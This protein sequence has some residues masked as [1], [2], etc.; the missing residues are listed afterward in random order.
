MATTRLVGLL[1]ASDSIS[2]SVNLLRREEK[3]KQQ[4]TDSRVFSCKVDGERAHDLNGIGID[5]QLGLP[6]LAFINIPKVHG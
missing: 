4:L 1:L 5:G 2:T 3:D 6:N